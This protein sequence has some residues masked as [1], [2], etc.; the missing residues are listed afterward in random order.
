MSSNRFSIVGGSILAWGISKLTRYNSTIIS[1]SI[2]SLVAPSIVKHG[3]AFGTPISDDYPL[4]SYLSLSFKDP[5][6]FIT[7][8]S[9]RYWLL[10]PG[11][12]IMLLYSFTEVF[13]SLGPMITSKSPPRG[14]LYPKLMA[15]EAR[16]I[17]T[18]I[19]SHGTKRALMKKMKTFLL[20]QTA[21]PHSGGPSVFSPAQSCAALSFLKF[22]I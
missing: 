8:P 13:L 15:Q 22:S 18:G 6:A 20:S 17:L 10:W 5:E 14:C 2:L 7:H 16:E 19:L 11:V 12:L 21:F 3:L 1:T 4:V 9:P